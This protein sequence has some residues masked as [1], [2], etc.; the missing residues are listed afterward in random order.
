M[1]TDSGRA[2]TQASVWL[3]YADGER[4]YQA[5]SGTIPDFHDLRSAT[6]HLL[7]IEA[8]EL[9]VWL[10][11]V[12]PQGQSEHLP[13]LVKVSSGKDTREF[14]VDGARNQFVLPL[15]NAV[16]KESKGRAGEP[17]QLE[18]EVQLAANKASD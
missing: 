4:V 3:G 5:A 17:R 1:V 9:R 8:Q 18:V 10:H 13:A 15:L 16:K 12:T 7:G 6:F 14:H 2:A 11:R